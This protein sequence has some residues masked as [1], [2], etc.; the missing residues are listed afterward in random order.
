MLGPGQDPVRGQGT[1]WAGSRVALSA[2]L[3][4]QT[5][6]GPAWAGSVLTLGC[7][8]EKSAPVPPWDLGDELPGSSLA[9]A[10]SFVV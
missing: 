7:G 2:G 1:Y 5:V 8:A 6:T 3:V 10:S 4:R 9:A